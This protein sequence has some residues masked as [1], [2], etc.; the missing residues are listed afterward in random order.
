M[1][2][3]VVSDI[4]AIQDGGQCGMGAG[5]QIGATQPTELIEVAEVR[6]DGEETLETIPLQLREKLGVL[7]GTLAGGRDDT[8]R[9]LCGRDGDILDVDVI[10]V[11]SDQR[12]GLIERSEAVWT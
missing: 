11:V 12:P 7:A 9:V 10:D 1:Y 3:S 6:F 5:P 2:S 8:D 4:E